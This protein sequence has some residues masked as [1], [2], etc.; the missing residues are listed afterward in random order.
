MK[1]AAVTIRKRYEGLS[2]PSLLTDRVPLLKNSQDEA[3]FSRE[4]HQTMM[5]FQSLDDLKVASV[6]KGTRYAGH[7][8]SYLLFRRPELN[9]CNHHRPSVGIC[10]VMY[11]LDV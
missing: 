9:F 4:M 8:L 10:S 6:I 5:A 1:V 11:F 3:Q 7:F 2:V